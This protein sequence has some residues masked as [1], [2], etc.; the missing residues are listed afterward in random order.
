MVQAKGLMRTCTPIPVFLF[1]LPRLQIS[2]KV[3]SCDLKYHLGT[4]KKPPSSTTAISSPKWS[5]PTSD[6]STQTTNDLGINSR[7]QATPITSTTAKE[8]LNTNLDCH[9][10][11]LPATLDPEP[12]QPRSTCSPQ[13]LQPTR[14]ITSSPH[15]QQP[16]YASILQRPASS[17]QS[18]PKPDKPVP[19]TIPTLRIE[20]L[21][22]RFH[23]KSSPFQLEKKRS[24]RSMKRTRN[25]P[26]TATQS[27]SRFLASALPAFS[28]F[29]TEMQPKSDAC[30]PSHS[31][32]NY[33]RAMRAA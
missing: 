7:T 25:K 4:T 30:Y 27:L 1:E 3:I 22:R 5:N 17:T 15:N 20:G 10:N 21:H 18:T 9:S 26:A 13:P 28:R 32:F 8:Q 16:T 12:Q 24:Q 23:N 19:P 33:S 29:L 31:Q 6:S 14:V 2:L 11:P